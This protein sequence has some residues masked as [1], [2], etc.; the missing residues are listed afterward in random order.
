MAKETWWND[1]QAEPKRAYRW[2]VYFGGLSEYIAKKVS[3]PSFTVT[4]T[5][6][7]YLNHK[8]YYPGRVEWNTINLTVV[9]SVSPNAS[10]EILQM[11]SAAGYKVPKSAGTAK[12]TMSKAAAIN[13]LKEVKIHQLKPDGTPMETWTLSGCWIKDV[14]FGELDYESDDMIEIELE[15]RYDFAELG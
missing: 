4:E 6:H 7:T 8:F 13:R 9:D 15:L 5:A 11:I 3:K 14:K 1:A 2:T 10:S 12:H